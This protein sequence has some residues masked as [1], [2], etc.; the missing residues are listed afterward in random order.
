ML[1]QQGQVMMR[2]SMRY[3]KPVSGKQLGQTW[4]QGC[5]T[6]PDRFPQVYSDKVVEVAGF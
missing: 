6:D 3:T 4:T 2:V 1:S 5:G